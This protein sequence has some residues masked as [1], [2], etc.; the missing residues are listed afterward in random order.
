[1]ALRRRPVYLRRG[2]ASGGRR[3]GVAR[4]AAPRPCTQ[5]R[6]ACGA[7]NSSARRGRPR[8]RHALPPLLPTQVALTSPP[9]PP[10][11]P[12]CWLQVGTALASQHYRGAATDDAEHW[13]CRRRHPSRGRCA[14]RSARSGRWAGSRPSVMPT[15]QPSVACY[16]HATSCTTPASSHRFL[17]CSCRAPHRGCAGPVPVLAWPTR[18]G[19]ALWQHEHTQRR[20]ND[21]SG[22][23]QRRNKWM[24]DGPALVSCSQPCCCP[25]DRVTL[26]M[27][28]IPTAQHK[29]GDVLTKPHPGLFAPQALPQAA[30]LGAPARAQPVRLCSQPRSSHA[31]QGAWFNMRLG[32]VRLA[33]L[34]AK[35]AQ[36]WKAYGSWV[37]RCFSVCTSDPSS[38]GGGASGRGGC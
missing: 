12:S 32:E 22:D 6:A 1:M 4:R 38:A 5:T 19:Q 33:R 9:C 14:K 11:P 7:T 27:G 13:A 26:E 36:S 8:A 29:G 23:N 2:P 24:A 17:P 20:C 3:R 34:H 28:D 25:M 15:P 10:D 16:S 35:S 18:H 37:P 31:H 30:W 21:G